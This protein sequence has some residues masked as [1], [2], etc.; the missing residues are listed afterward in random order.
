MPKLN[1]FYPTDLFN[2]DSDTWKDFLDDLSAVTAVEMDAIDPATG[3]RTDFHPDM[4]IDIL[5]FP[6]EAATSRPTAVVLIEIITYAWPDRMDTIN[7]RLK[8]IATTVN[9][10]VRRSWITI[11]KAAVNVT[12]LGKSEGCWVEM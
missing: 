5:S 10:Y 7:D 12:F 2:N 3:E 4:S 9:R 6:Y 11:P 8:A 1:V